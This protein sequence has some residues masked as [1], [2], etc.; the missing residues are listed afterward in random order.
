ML[1]SQSVTGWNCR[2]IKSCLAPARRRRLLDEGFGSDDSSPAQSVVVVPARRNRSW[3]RLSAPRRWLRASSIPVRGW[4]R[5]RCSAPPRN[6]RKQCARSRAAPLPD[7][8]PANWRA[9]RSPSSG[10]ANSPASQPRGGS[11]WPGATNRASVQTT[12]D[13][14]RPPIAARAG[15]G[16]LQPLPSPDRRRETPR[17]QPAKSFTAISPAN[18]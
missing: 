8:R 6:R 5:P 13:Q 3:C 4:R 11:S 17:A 9:R 10:A 15:I 1:P 7:A 14:H 12:I 18:S 2:P 16:E